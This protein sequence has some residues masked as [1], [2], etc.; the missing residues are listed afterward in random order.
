VTEPAARRTVT[1]V[2]PPAEPGSRLSSPRFAGLPRVE[3]SREEGSA[4]GTYTVRIVD[5]AGKPLGDAEVLLLAR[6]PDGTVENV[7]M[8]FY[9]DHGTYRGALPPSHSSP[10]DLRVRVITGDKRVEIPLGR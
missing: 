9:P 7:R 3:L 1:A 5:P 10:V 6:M 4:S 2:P 8:N